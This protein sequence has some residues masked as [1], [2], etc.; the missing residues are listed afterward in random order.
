[1]DAQKRV[2]KCIVW[3]EGMGSYSLVSSLLFSHSV[4]LNR[5]TEK[6]GPIVYP[7]L[8]AGC[9]HTGIFLWVAYS[10]PL[11]DLGISTRR[12]DLSYHSLWGYEQRFHMKALTA[13]NWGGWGGL[14]VQPSKWYCSALAL[15]HFFPFNRTFF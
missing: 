2:G 7:T 4:V 14:E 12:C 11:H 13:A 5:K 3:A 1:M 8:D 15:H 6:I 10:M 9:F